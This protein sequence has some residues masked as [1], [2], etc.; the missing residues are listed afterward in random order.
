MFVSEFRFRHRFIEPDLT[1]NQWELDISIDDQMKEIEKYIT[2]SG[3]EPIF[4]NF[5]YSHRFYCA[6]TAPFMHL[7]FEYEDLQKLLDSACAGDIIDIW[8]LTDNPKK[9]T[10]NCPNFDGL[11]PKKGAY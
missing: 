5:V 1:K 2:Y 8:M 7:G 11:F 6:A 10:L 4:E 3:E 9:F